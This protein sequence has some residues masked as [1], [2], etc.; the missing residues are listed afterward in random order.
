MVLRV[1]LLATDFSPQGTNSFL[2]GQ[3]G[4]PRLLIDTTSTGD[5]LNRYLEVLERELRSS[6]AILLSSF[7][8]ISAILLTHWHPDH[9]GGITAVQVR[10]LRIADPVKLTSATLA[11]IGSYLKN[12]SFTS[13]VEQADSSGSTISNELIRHIVSCVCRILFI[14]TVSV[15]VAHFQ[16]KISHTPSGTY[17]PNAISHARAASSTRCRGQERVGHLGGAFFDSRNPIPAAV[18]VTRAPSVT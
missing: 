18:L 1:T 4:T 12:I 16:L 11:L 10:N 7:S 17:D 3:P 14:S 15:R 8:P 2:V 13:N 9:S 5:C 6:S